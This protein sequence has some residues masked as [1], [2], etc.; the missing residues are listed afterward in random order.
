MFQM[1][2]ITASI[3]PMNLPWLN[4]DESPSTQ[5]K[6]FDFL[7]RNNKVVEK[8]DWVL[9]NS[10]LELEPQGFNLVPKALPI[11]PFLATNRLGNLSG[12]FWPEDSTC[13]Q[14]LDQQSPGS[15]S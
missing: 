15:V 6:L 2:L 12:N 13:L 14:W 1:S 10:S 4:I 5:K 3:H 9:S 8:T 7:L 11:G